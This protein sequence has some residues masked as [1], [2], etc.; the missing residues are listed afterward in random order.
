[1]VGGSSPQCPQ[2]YCAVTA[3]RREHAPIWAEGYAVYPISV[4]FKDVQESSH[5]WRRRL[6]RVEFRLVI[7]ALEPA[8]ILALASVLNVQPR[9]HDHHQFHLA[10]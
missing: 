3:S 2:S 8:S 5:C 1:M 7:L 9:H 10:C 6:R 4:P